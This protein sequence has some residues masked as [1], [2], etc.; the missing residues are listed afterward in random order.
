LSLRVLVKRYNFYKVIADNTTLSSSGPDGTVLIRSTVSDYPAPR[1]HIKNG[2]D[3]PTAQYPENSALC[4]HLTWFGPCYVARR[5]GIRW[6]YL[7]IGDVP[8]TK[9]LSKGLGFV[10]RVP[11]EHTGRRA[12]GNERVALKED[13]GIN[14]KRVANAI[15]NGNGGAYATDLDVQPAMEVE[16]PFYSS[17]RFVN[18][19]WDDYNKIG[20]HRHS[21][22]LL[23]YNTD[24][25]KC[26]D[27]WMS[28]VAAG[29]DFNF[30]WMISCPPFRLI[31]LNT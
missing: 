10:N 14:P 21:I 28:Y 18:P 19:R 17:L 9:D 8:S 7:H 27:A 25:S 5:G 16:L 22:E 29:D 31:D 4:T 23:A 24:S 20:I 11:Q 12:L 13:N 26:R 2:P 30:S 6:K 3:N 1:G 15:S